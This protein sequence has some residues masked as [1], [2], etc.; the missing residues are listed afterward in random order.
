MLLVV[1]SLSGGVA[2]GE[3][4]LP[5]SE[6]TNKNKSN[7]QSSELCAS[8]T[9]SGCIFRRNLRAAI[10]VSNTYFH[11]YYCCIRHL[12]LFWLG[13]GYNKAW[14]VSK[15]IERLLCLDDCTHLH[16][17]GVSHRRKIRM[18]E[19]L[20]LFWRFIGEGLNTR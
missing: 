18:F 2:F 19:F 16:R 20:K 17:N 13:G 1:R 15:C 3:F 8:S 5:I 14:L 9:P 11:Y 6:N 7:K 4:K 10:R 12:L